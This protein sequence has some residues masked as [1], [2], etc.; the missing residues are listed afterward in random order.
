MSVLILSSHGRFCE[1]LKES[2]EMIFGPQEK[3]V[4]LPFLEEEGEA[5]FL[6]KFKAIKNAHPE[7]ELVAFAD[8]F[9]GTPCN[10]LSKLV[11][12]GESLSLYSGMNMP[13][14]ISFLN[15]QLTGQD[16]NG[17]TDAQDGIKFV[18]DLL[19]KL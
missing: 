1:A 10:Q 4:T 11:M 3:I 7:E 5:E 12:T 14:V 15:A 6:A 2:V 16:F 18:N 19:P 13:M 9:G 8:L 17:V